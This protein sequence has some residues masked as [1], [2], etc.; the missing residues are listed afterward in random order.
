MNEEKSFNDA[1]IMMFWYTMQGGILMLIPFI[2]ILNHYVHIGPI[3][4]NL[5]NVFIG[6]CF[7]SI[8]APF[9]LLGYFKRMQLK[10]R[11]DIQSGQEPAPEEL[12]R[13]FIFLLI[14]MSLCHLS[15]MLGLV[16]YIIASNLKY[17]LFFIG[18]SFLLGFLYK[19]SLK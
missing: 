10:I 3:M 19:P 15:G 16:L 2:Y 6:I 7:I 14:G 12:Q 17:T 9:S 8:A 11:G 5:N 13:L 4:P 18:V 1:T